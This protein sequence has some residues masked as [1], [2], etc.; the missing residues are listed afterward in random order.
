MPLKFAEPGPD[1]IPLHVL[2]SAALKD[3]L[4]DQPEAIRTWVQL[5]GL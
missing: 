2:E 1:D 3:W 5:N 4:A